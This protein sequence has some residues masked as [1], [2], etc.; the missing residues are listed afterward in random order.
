MYKNCTCGA[1]SVTM[2]FRN[3]DSSYAV[4]GLKPVVNF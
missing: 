4:T 2:Y 3:L 1:V